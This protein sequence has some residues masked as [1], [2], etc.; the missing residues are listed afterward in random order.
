ML[1]KSA[2]VVAAARAKGI[3]VIHA[4]IMFKEDASDNPNKC[5]GIL[6]GCAKD[7]LFTQG[8]VATRRPDFRDGGLPST[9]RLRPEF[10]RESLAT[11]SH[12]SHGYES[13]RWGWRRRL[14][15]D[16]APQPRG[17]GQ[18]GRG[19]RRRRAEAKA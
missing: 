13:R 17:R 1:E 11:L 5:L 12:R 4:P 9:L 2:K 6:A 16:H 7:K 10:T 18:E 19:G 3:T 15:G 8:T 14:Q